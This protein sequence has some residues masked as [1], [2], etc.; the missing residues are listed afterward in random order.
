MSS[1]YRSTQG[2]NGWSY[3]FTI[4][5][6]LAIGWFTGF[7]PA[8]WNATQWYFGWVTP[9]P[10]AT[11]DPFATTVPTLV[12]TATPQAGIGDTYLEFPIGTTDVLIVYNHYRIG[13]YEYSD[14]NYTGIN[15]TYYCLLGGVYIE[16]VPVV[17]PLSDLDVPRSQRYGQPTP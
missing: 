7:C 15:A 9:A 10:T 1:R 16:C 3:A 2:T 11:F 5:V 17:R 8:V 6:F 4:V 13:A 12:P 14:Y